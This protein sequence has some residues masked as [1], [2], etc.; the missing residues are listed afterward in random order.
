MIKRLLAILETWVQSLGRED[1]L[2]KEMA[3]HS[4]TLVWKIP[5]A[6]E[7]GRLQSLGPQRAGH[8]FTFTFM[9]DLLCCI[10]SSVQQSDMVIYILSFLTL[11]QR[12][13]ETSLVAQWIWVCL[14][15]QGTWVQSLVE[16]DSTYCG[17]TKPMC[18]NYQAHALEPAS[19]NCWAHVPRTC[20]LQQEKPPQWEAVRCNREQPLLC[21]N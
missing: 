10:I 5:W 13:W 4:S 15:T 7:L 3:T 12:V 11:K 16:E 1:P 8:D 20:A 21:R 18:H 9:V 2:E 19:H 6:E 14:P 17:E